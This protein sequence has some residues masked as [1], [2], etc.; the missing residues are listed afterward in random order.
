MPMLACDDAS[1]ALD[2]YRDAFGAEEVARLVGPDGKI[3]YAEIKIG[4]ATLSVSDV[5]PG[6][7]HTPKS[8][9]GWTVVLNLQV[10]DVDAFCARAVA[11]GANQVL[12][13]DDQFYGDRSGRIEDPFGHVWII[14][15]HR[16]D[17]SFEEM[18]KRFDAMCGEG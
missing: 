12:P 1:A 10:E 7:N 4:E 8:L 18:Q 17:V 9:G 2:W 16:E 6:Y 11:A 15:T 3:G 13:V 14:A 5:W